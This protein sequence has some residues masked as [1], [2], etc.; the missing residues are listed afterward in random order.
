MTAKYG[1]Y[2]NFFCPQGGDIPPLVLSGGGGVRTPSWRKPWCDGNLA[3]KMCGAKVT[4][5]LAHRLRRWAN[6]D[7]TMVERLDYVGKR[8]DT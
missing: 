7:L 8:Q 4:S 1:I 6:I 5:M 2:F 3:I